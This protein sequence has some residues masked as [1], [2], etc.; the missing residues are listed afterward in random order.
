M[1]TDGSVAISGKQAKL[2]LTR[3]T[4][5]CQMKVRTTA[6][7]VDVSER[8]ARSTKAIMT[9]VNS[10]SESRGGAAAAAADGIAGNMYKAGREARSS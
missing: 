3:R 10:S 6:R 4:C 7:A 2:P 5:P 1:V 8:P 9:I